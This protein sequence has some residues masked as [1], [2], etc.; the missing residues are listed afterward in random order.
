[1]SGLAPQNDFR[2]TF[3]EWEMRVFLNADKY[4][5]NLIEGVFMA[6]RFSNNRKRIELR[7]FPEALALARGARRALLYAITNDGR[8]ACLEQ[9]H[10]AAYEQEWPRAKL[11]PKLKRERLE[12][13]EKK[14]HG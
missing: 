9:R 2:G 10:W 12:R 1:M 3:T 13:I 5:V 6:G 11:G 4:V 8:H 14:S 7:S